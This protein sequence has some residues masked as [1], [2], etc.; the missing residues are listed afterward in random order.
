MWFLEY[1]LILYAIGFAVVGILELAARL[2]WLA[3]RFAA[4]NGCYRAILGTAW[5]P[6]IFAIP[7]AGTLMLMRGA[8]LEDPPGFLPV[9][10]IVIAYT[11]PFFFGWLLYRNRDLL[12]TF[13]R[14]A[15]KQTVLALAL[16][17]AWLL[18]I[19]PIQNRPEYWV[20]VKPLRR[21][22]AR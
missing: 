3:A 15:W 10:R 12:D 9:P 8:F 21:Q 17:G 1:L 11:M 18:L 16:L 7:S 19:A 14:H 6:V 2:P 22:R 4:M 5:R 20:W 13:R